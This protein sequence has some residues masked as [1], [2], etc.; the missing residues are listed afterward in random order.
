MQEF[1]DWRTPSKLLP[2]I[3]NSISVNPH[4]SARVEPRFKG[5]H[6]KR[7]YVIAIYNKDTLAGHF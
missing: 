1:N 7:K 2:Q 5:N 6:T 3:Q 4:A